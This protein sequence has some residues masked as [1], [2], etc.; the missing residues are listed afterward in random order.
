MFPSGP[1]GLNSTRLDS[2]VPFVS[3]DKQTG[4]TVPPANPDALAA[5]INRLL[6]DDALRQSFGRAAALRARQEFSL[7]SMTSR[8]VALYD[9]VLASS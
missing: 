5:A 8:T 4:L 9:R 3:L 7:E 2:G 1:A 6:D